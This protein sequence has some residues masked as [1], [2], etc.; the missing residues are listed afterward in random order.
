MLQ[1]VAE[2]VPAAVLDIYL[3]ARDRVREKKQA[4]EHAHEM[5]QL[6][7]RLRKE[8]ANQITPVRCLIIEKVLT[9]ACPRCGA[10]FLDFDGC[11]ALTCASPGCGCG[12]CA[13]C[14]EDCG[15]DA[16]SHTVRCKFITEGNGPFASQT[17]F[18]AM[19]TAWRVSKLKQV[20]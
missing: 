7:E 20:R 13:V 10:A 2:H 15:G 4:E 12:F 17:S 5:Q 18:K 11:M 8:L 9:T 6:E 3:K 1:D 14:L 19:Q 16:H